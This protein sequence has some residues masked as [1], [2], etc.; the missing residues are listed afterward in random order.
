MTLRHVSSSLNQFLP[1]QYDAVR[2]GKV[3]NNPKEL[4]HS[5]IMEVIGCYAR[6]ADSFM[7]RRPV[8]PG[9]PKSIDDV[10]SLALTFHS[11]LSA[12]S[13]GDEVPCS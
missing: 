2:A 9:K 13:A 4:I 6:V 5:K 7:V 3:A 11:E 10:P 1:R 12:A 8:M